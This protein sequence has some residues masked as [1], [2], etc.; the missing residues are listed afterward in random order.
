MIK[1]FYWHDGKVYN[2]GG[3]HIDDCTW[4]RAQAIFAGVKALVP[5]FSDT[6]EVRLVK[7]LPK[8]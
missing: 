5:F 1:T 8:Q 6:A 7:G 2:D 3:K 4:E